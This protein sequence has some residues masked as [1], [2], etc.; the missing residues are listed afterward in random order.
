MTL[1]SGRDV[2]PARDRAVFLNQFLLSAVALLGVVLALV[3]RT[4]ADLG[5][6][7]AGGALAFVITGAALLVPWNRLPPSAIAI[8]P[9]ADIAMIAVLRE[10][11]QSTSGFGL[12]W[13]F[14]AMWAA[15]AFGWLGTTISVMLITGIYWLRIGPPD[16]PITGTAVL[17]PIMIAATATISYFMASRASGQRLLLEQ[18]SVALRQ[19]VARGRR[20]EDLLTDVLEAVDFGVIRVDPDGTQTVANEAHARLAATAAEAGG[21]YAA[22]GHTRLDPERLP[23]ARALAGEAFE[24]ELAWFGAPGERRHALS[25]TAKQLRGEDGRPAGTLVVTQDVTR[26]ALAIRARDDL[27]ATVSHELRNPLTAIIGYLDLALDDPA[28]PEGARRSLEIAERNGERLLALIADILAVSEAS[29]SGAAISVAPR[30]IDL[31]PVARRAIETA[32]LPADA[33]G[34]RIELEAAGPAVALADELR[35]RQ[36]LDNLLSNAIK[37]GREGGRVEVGCSKAGDQVRVE[38]RDDGDGIAPDDLPLVFDRF[39]RADAIR[40]TATHGYGLGLAISRQIARAHGGDLLAENAEGGG[41]LFTLLL[42]SG[43][44]DAGDAS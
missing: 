18:Q 9:A 25:V 31:V 40:K 34:M 15:W 20:Q 43:R 14:P 23:L 27:V 3:F 11:G 32:R 44:E 8:I 1:V 2:D 38:V 21:A 24:R 35:V 6:L 4:F 28:L 42:P 22:D 7:V 13:V 19:A 41:A 10:G 39:Y 30:P 16:A 36:V 12:L 33:R 26:E 5:L 29:A 17:L 37:Y